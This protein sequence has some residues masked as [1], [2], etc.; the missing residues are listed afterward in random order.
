MKKT[1]RAKRI[2][3]GLMCGLIAIGVSARGFDKTLKD[4]KNGISFSVHTKVV[5]LDHSTV[6]V[7]V[8]GPKMAAKVR[9]KLDYATVD[10][11]EVADLNGDGMPELYLFTLSMGN[12]GYQT[13]LGFA[14]TKDR[15]LVPIRYKEPADNTKVMRGY[16]GFDEYFIVGNELIRRFPIYRGDDEPQCCPTGGHRLL[17]Y[18]LVPDSNGFRLKLSRTEHRS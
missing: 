12:G 7:S 15:R 16:R 3:V 5:P 18:K 1:I 14:V 9:K 17:Y 10:R 11:A 4:S 13:L 6:T 2:M 8:R